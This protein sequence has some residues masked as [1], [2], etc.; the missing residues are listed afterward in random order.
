MS[1]HIF[2]FIFKLRHC[3]YFTS[4]KIKW[5]ASVHICPDSGQVLSQPHV[6]HGPSVKPD[7]TRPLS[8][9]LPCRMNRSSIEPR[10]AV[11]RWCPLTFTSATCWSCSPAPGRG[12]PSRTPWGSS[13]RAQ[14]TGT[15]NTTGHFQELPPDRSL[16]EGQLMRRRLL[17]RKD[18]DG[19]QEMWA[20]NVLTEKWS[21]CFFYKVD[22]KNNASLAWGL[23][24]SLSEFDKLSMWRCHNSCMW[25]MFLGL[26]M[27]VYQPKV[28][29]VLCGGRK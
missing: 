7:K 26:R 1:W 19:L 21:F 20:V 10:D 22:I 29:S 3:N 18:W 4:E 8:L 11:S 14:F 2:A 5:E 28:C 16:A 13:R 9:L 27:E 12:G 15:S 24:L 25:R 6:A 17:S 23:F